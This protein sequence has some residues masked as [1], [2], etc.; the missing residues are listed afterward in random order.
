M[1]CKLTPYCIPNSYGVD[2]I[3]QTNN[4]SPVVAITAYETINILLTT[5][6]VTHH[7]NPEPFICT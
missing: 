5:C 7:E 1:R 4:V 3:Q 2:A 6:T